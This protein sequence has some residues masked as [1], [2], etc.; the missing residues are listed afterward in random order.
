MII[1]LFHCGAHCTLGAIVAETALFTAGLDAAGSTWWARYAG[2]YLA[3]VV[4]GV[5]FRYSVGTH[6]RGRR[7]TAAIT[8]VVRVDLVSVSAFEFT[9]F[10]WL[11]LVA[12][13]AFPTAPRPDSPV[14]WFVTQVGLIAGFAAAWP[15]TSL[16]A[17]RGV[18]LEPP[19]TPT[20]VR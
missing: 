19:G 1:Q 10:G 3:A 8:T 17:R 2:D 14:F 15:A 9:L 7:I 13:V 16:L 6:P 11:A 18:V 4:I 12:R 5:I 20:P